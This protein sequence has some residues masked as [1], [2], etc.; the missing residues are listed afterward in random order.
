MTRSW[1][2][3]IGCLALTMTA[4]VRTVWETIE[5]PVPT[6]VHVPPPPVCL[7]APSVR[8]FLKEQDYCTDRAGAIRLIARETVRL[9]CLAAWQAWAQAVCSTAGVACGGEDVPRP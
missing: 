7:E 4:C 2:A 6:T 9:D 5:I 3:L 1:I 8:F